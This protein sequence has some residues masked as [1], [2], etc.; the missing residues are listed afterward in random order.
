MTATHEKVETDLLSN[1]LSYEQLVEK[2]P[3]LFRSVETI[4]YFV[5]HRDENG[6][7]E[8]GAIVKAGKSFRIYYDKFA[9]WYLEH[10]ALGAQRRA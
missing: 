3:E 5:R 9:N 8:T 2:H 10:G 4:K 1:L 6:L 7:S